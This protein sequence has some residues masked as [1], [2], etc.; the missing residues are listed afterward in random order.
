MGV[1]LSPEG[2]ALANL[3]TP[4]KLGL[5]GPIAGGWRWLS[6][7]SL[8]DTVGAIE[9]ALTD[10]SWRGPAIVAATEPVT[11]EDFTKTLGEC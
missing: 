11:N 9:H 5:G 3:L 8:D 6:W 7:I 2:G 4:F 10:D 1:V